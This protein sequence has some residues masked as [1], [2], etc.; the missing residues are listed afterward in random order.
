MSKTA[1]T[2]SLAEQIRDTARTKKPVEAELKTDKRVLARI[3]DGIYRQ[4]A[5]ALRELISN[6]YDADATEVVILTDA[7][8]FS[9]ITV[10]DDGLGLSLD[11]LQH[12]IEHIGGSAKRTKYGADLDVTAEDDPTRSKGGR[13]LIGKLGIGLFSVAQFTRHFL[14]ITKTRGTKFRTV[15]DITLGAVDEELEPLNSDESED[16]D[17]TKGHARIWVERATDIES[18]GTEVKLLDPLPRTRAELASFDLWARIDFEKETEG[19][20]L[21][22]EPVF[23]IGRMNRDRPDELISKPRLPWMEKDKPKARFEKLVAAVRG[24]AKTEKDLVDLDSDCD[25]YLQTLWTLALS[26]PLEYLESHPFDL[27]ANSDLRFYQLENKTKGQAKRLQPK[28][29]ESLRKILGLK[30]PCLKR[31]DR[32]E[33]FMDGVQLFRPIV[34]MN[35]PKTQNAVKTPLLFAG[36]CRE[37]FTGKPISLS[38]GPLEFEAYLLWTPKVLPTQ[39]QGVMIRVGNASG[40]PFDRTFMGYQVSEQTRLRQIT[41]EIFVR[42]GLD[43]AINLDRESFNYAHPHYQ[44]LVKWLHSALRQLTN[45]QK[46][47]G[48]EVRSDRLAREGVKAHRKLERLV[49]KQLKDHGV[50][51][52]AEVVLLDPIRQSEAPD[53]RDQGV[54]ALRKRFVLPESQA[55]RQTAKEQERAAFMERKA[56]AIAQILHAWGLLESLSFQDQEKLVHDILEVAA[57]EVEQ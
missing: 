39:H 5:S 14:I 3:T 56:V 37:E 10:R 4:P 13:Q 29:G 55:V 22:R 34:F 57:A 23:H 31:G 17:I 49:E 48:S 7:P 35:Q 33:V 24:L 27:A 43:G 36:H 11:A 19:K 18:Q 42:E 8:R 30:T 32:F 44:F 50:E 28:H 25:R 54:V 1:K 6:A 46:E 47:V 9:A 40:A 21:T 12:L 2:I 15:A 53:L 26:A 20:A 38:G 45:R 41:A 16:R 51:D 52:L